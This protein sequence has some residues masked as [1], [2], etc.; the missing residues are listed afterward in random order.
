MI[1]CILINMTP[2]LYIFIRTD[3]IPSPSSLLQ[4]EQFQVSQPVLIGEILQ[5]SD[6]LQKKKKTLKKILAVALLASPVQIPSSCELWQCLM[7]S[8]GLV[9]PFSCI[10][11]DQ[12]DNTFQNALQVFPGIWLERL[13]ICCTVPEPTNS[14]VSERNLEIIPWELAAVI[15]KKKTSYSC[16]VGNDRS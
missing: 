1:E 8:I 16:S 4:A 14:S 10:Y 11:Y 12:V 2:A 9:P 6:H 15:K 5:P 13:Y 3:E 7:S